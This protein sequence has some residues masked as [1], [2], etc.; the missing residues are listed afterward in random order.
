MSL[1]M[2]ARGW[3]L[4]GFIAVALGALAQ[5][6]QLSLEPNHNSGQSIT[7]AFEGWFTNPDGSFSL[8]L[9]YYNR[10]LEEEIEIP[11]GENNRIEP[12]GP[13]RGQPTHFMPGRMWGVFIVTVPKDFGANTLTWTIVAHGKPT[14]IPMSLNPLWEVSPLKDAI[15]NTPPFL[16]FQSF[17]SG[18]PWAQG[19]RAL[20]ESLTAS[21]SHPL[22]LNIWV[23]DDVKLSP[24][25]IRPKAPITVAWSKFRG[26]GA[27]VFANSKP[28][29]EVPGKFPP[30]AVFGGTATTTAKFSQPGQY[31]LYL[32][33]NDASGVGGGGFQC[34]WTNG[35]VNVSVEPAVRGGE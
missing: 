25:R 20:T 31:V 28:A 19:P 35:F 18:G 29:V 17:D 7:G 30:P 12:G 32:M 3:K 22:P 6:Q 26:P 27:V 21:V 13:D 1:A 34:C 8:L 10:N 33:V 5:S 24:G 14:V 4:V 11:I 2:W 9:G 15:G 16:S 23:A